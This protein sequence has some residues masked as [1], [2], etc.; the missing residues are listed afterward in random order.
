MRWGFEPVRNLESLVFAPSTS[1]NDKKQQQDDEEEEDN[2]APVFSDEED[3]QAEESGD[4]SDDGDYEEP[5][6]LV[7]DDSEDNQEAEEPSHEPLNSSSKK[8]KRADNDKAEERPAK[9]LRMSDLTCVHLWAF[10]ADTLPTS[11]AKMQMLILQQAQSID[12]KHVACGV[13]YF[14]PF[15]QDE[16]AYH[17]F[18][19]N[20]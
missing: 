5:N 2:D 11:L 1:T 16:Q 8:R 12:K 18:L 17:A 10:N 7:D 20:Q 13:K 15:V 9:R 19:N 3:E 4:D 14:A 6:T